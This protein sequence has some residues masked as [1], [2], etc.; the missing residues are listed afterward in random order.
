MVISAAPAQ[1][2]EDSLLWQE[3]PPGG[4]SFYTGSR[5]LLRTP[6]EEPGFDL[7]DPRRIGLPFPKQLSGGRPEAAQVGGR[8]PE[9]SLGRQSA[10]LS[11]PYRMPSSSSTK[12][13]TSNV[14]KPQRFIRMQ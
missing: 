6:H 8:D 7:R 10:F 13:K 12:K 3:F 11:P 4:P 5:S 1:G 2:R 9:C 14:R